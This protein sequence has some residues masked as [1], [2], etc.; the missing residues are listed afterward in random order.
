VDDTLAPRLMFAADNGKLWLSLRPG[1][2]QNPNSGQVVTLG[3]IVLGSPT[4]G[5]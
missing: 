4:V 5:H 2:A 3:S 1:N